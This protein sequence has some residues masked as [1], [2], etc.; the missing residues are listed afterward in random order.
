MVIFSTAI[1]EYAVEDF[2][3]K[4]TGYIL[5]PFEF[6]RFLQAVEKAQIQYNYLHQ[7]NTNNVEHLFVRSG[8]S[9]VKIPFSEILL[10]ETL[11]DYIKIYSIGRKPILTLLTL[12]LLQKSCQQL[13]FSE[14]IVLILFQLKKLNL[15]AEKQ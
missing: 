2:N 13:I 7:N 12:K 6:N 11:D 4:A 15:L 1:S 9:L 5:K 14:C 8:Y 3:L 10:I